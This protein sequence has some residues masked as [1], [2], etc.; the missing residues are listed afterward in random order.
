MEIK[1]NQNSKYIDTKK[2][3]SPGFLLGFMFFHGIL[4]LGVGYLFSWR[5][6]NITIF[7]SGFGILIY[8]LF[9]KQHFPKIFRNAIYGAII[10]ILIGLIFGDWLLDNFYFGMENV[11]FL[12]RIYSVIIVFYIYVYIDI[13]IKFWRRRREESNKSS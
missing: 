9:L 10:S 4:F 7:H 3:T 6:P 13:F 2:I 12:H 11:T 8:L 5:I 1:P